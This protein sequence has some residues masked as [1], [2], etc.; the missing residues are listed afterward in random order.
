M[1]RLEKDMQIDAG[2]IAL[3]FLE[4]A[5]NDCPGEAWLVPG[6]GVSLRIRGGI[7]LQRGGRERLFS[8]ADR[9]HVRRDG[10]VDGRCE[11]VDSVSADWKP[12]SRVKQVG[13]VGTNIGELQTLYRAVVGRFKRSFVLKS[14]GGAGALCKTAIQGKTHAGVLRVAFRI[15]RLVGGIN[16]LG[17]AERIVEL[18]ARNAD[19]FEGRDFDN[20]AG[21]EL[22][23]LREE[24]GINLIIFD[25]EA[26]FVRGF[27]GP[28]SDK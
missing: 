12:E 3:V 9:D 27:G 20:R 15:Q 10:D 2:V 8:A 18:K 19:V 11:T 14:N 17:D 28:D 7:L 24:F 4:T 26:R 22:V 1:Q 5:G 16:E 21:R 25:A 23:V 13:C 6:E